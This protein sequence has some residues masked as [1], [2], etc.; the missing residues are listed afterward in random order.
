MKELTHTK[1]TPNGTS[2]QA[3]YSFCFNVFDSTVTDA[4]VLRLFFAPVYLVYALKTPEAEQLSRQE[5]WFEHYQETVRKAELE[6][7][8]MLSPSMQLRSRIHTLEQHLSS[9]V[10]EITGQDIHAYFSRNDHVKDFPER[11]AAAFFPKDGGSLHTFL[12]DYYHAL[13]YKLFWD[14][15]GLLDACISRL[16]ALNRDTSWYRVPTPDRRTTS[17]QEYFSRVDTAAELLYSFALLSATHDISIN[18]KKAARQRVIPDIF[19]AARRLLEIDDAEPDQ[20]DSLS[21]CVNR[22]QL[23]T[24]C[25]AA[26]DSRNRD[27]IRCLN[28][29]CSS[30]PSPGP[31]GAAH[32]QAIQHLLQ[33]LRQYS[34]DCLQRISADYD[35]HRDDIYLMGTIA[36][37]EAFWKQ[38]LR[39]SADDT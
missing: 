21:I 15:P 5:E 33:K 12:L 22:S 25:T 7:D 3:W 31:A 13:L 27:Q 24:L 37:L 19:N 29:I 14:F 6:D 23:L 17:T 4:T 26:A 8:P 34:N 39:S 18:P 1:T 32:R 30:C 11:F 28:E 36:D 2:G 10:R 20:E 16:E 9:S 35:K 38:Q